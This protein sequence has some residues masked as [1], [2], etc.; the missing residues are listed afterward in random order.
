MSKNPAA[1]ALGSIK[2]AKKACSSAANGAKGGRPR[3]IGA[4]RAGD[5]GI[6]VRGKKAIMVCNRGGQGRGHI[7]E[8]TIS[9]TAESGKAA[10]LKMAARLRWGE[11]EAQQAWAE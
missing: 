7:E 4:E 2:S 8:T 9:E 10:Y 1:V 11:A 3:I 5:F 6:K